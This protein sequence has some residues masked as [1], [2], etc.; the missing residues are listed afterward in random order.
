[1]EF[2]QTMVQRVG[3]FRRKTRQK[4]KKH[5]RAK[6]KIAIRH[7]LQQFKQGDHVEL[8]ADPGVQHGMYHPR[9]HGSAGE[10]LGAQGDCYRVAIYDG[11]SK[12]T[13]IVHPVHLRKAQ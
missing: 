4:L 8:K 3:G 12:K 6:G 7:Q 9:F 10:V 13:V 2:T 1:M 11:N 5:A